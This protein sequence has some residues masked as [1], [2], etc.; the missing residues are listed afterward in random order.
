MPQNKLQ[1][2]GLSKTY[3]KYSL[4]KKN[5]SHV[6]ETKAL[7]DVSFKLVPG[8]YGLLGP[9]GSG[10]ST[11]IKLIT[12]SLKK[13]SGVVLWNGKSVAGST[14]EF[15]R[16][17]GYAPQQQNLYNSYTGYRFLCYLAALK[18]IPREYME[19]EVLRVASKVNLT[20]DLNKKISTYSGGM[21]QRLL[22]ASALLGV[23]KI[24]IMDEPTAGLDPQERYRL[25]KL[26]SDISK[27]AIVLVATHV[28][29]DVEDV[30]DEILLLRKGHL[31]DKDA[32]QK[33]IQRYAPNKNLES[34]Y[35]AVFGEEDG[36]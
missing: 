33:L 9:N 32:P 36:A 16:A 28:V 17:L 23:P 8:L 20:D 7:E 10:K 27:T 34:V 12:G 3:K 30:A 29:S 15:R 31:V 35:L 24:L 1:I 2:A 21:K 6:Q 25:R 26:L 13:D 4:I 11:L 5:G 19:R 22:V 14:L 18:E